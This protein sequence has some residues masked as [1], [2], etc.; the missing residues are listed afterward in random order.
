MRAQTEWLENGL[1]GMCIKAVRMHEQA[2]NRAIL[3]TECNACQVAIPDI[4][5]KSTHVLPPENPAQQIGGA[6]DRIVPNAL[7][8]SRKIEEQAI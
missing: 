5:R 6:F 3:I 8:F 7:F 2:I 1:I 4:D